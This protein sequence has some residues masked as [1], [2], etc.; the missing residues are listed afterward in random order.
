MEWSHLDQSERR[1]KHWAFTHD[2]WSYFKLFILCH[3]CSHIQFLTRSYSLCRTKQYCSNECSHG[4]EADSHFIFMSTISMIHTSLLSSH[5]LCILYFW[6][7]LFAQLV[8]RAPTCDKEGSQ[9]V[10][11]SKLWWMK[12]MCELGGFPPQKNQNST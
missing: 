5:S 6:M 12:C 2:Y 10:C 9:H 8:V 4:S 7:I 11:V 1:K 3:S